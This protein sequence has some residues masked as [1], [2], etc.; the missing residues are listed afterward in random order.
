MNEETVRHQ[1]FF[2]RCKTFRKAFTPSKNGLCRTFS[3]FIHFEFSSFDLPLWIQPDFLLYLLKL[4]CHI[5][6]SLNNQ[7]SLFMFFYIKYVLFYV[8]LGRFSSDIS[9][10]LIGQSQCYKL[11]ASGSVV[12]N[13]IQIYLQL[14]Q[15]W[16]DFFFQTST[17]CFWAKTQWVFLSHV[18]LFVTIS[19]ILR[20]N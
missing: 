6:S 13:I 7:A 18:H 2:R 19:I 8:W 5:M 20:L 15:C 17:H 12:E 16:R 4:P 10:N 11:A 1:P 14:F 9:A 3:S